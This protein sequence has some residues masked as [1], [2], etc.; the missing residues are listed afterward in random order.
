[1]TALQISVGSCAMLA[2]RVFVDKKYSGYWGSKPCT[3]VVKG[4]IDF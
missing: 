2:G 3:V 4:T 1:M